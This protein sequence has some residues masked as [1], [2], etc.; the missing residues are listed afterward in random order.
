MTVPFSEKF[1]LITRAYRE[2]D[3][4]L[5]F[6]SI[7]EYRAADGRVI[8]DYQRPFLLPYNTTSIAFLNNGYRSSVNA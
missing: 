7:S 3:Q 5:I 6:D 8:I 1:H 2:S 4:P